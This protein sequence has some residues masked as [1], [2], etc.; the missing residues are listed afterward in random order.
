MTTPTDESRKARQT[1]KS[2]A[3]EP[4]CE[5]GCIDDAWEAGAA[6]AFEQASKDAANWHGTPWG[7]SEKLAARGKEQGK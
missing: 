5:H 7:L 1:W 6:W 3:K 2:T 4:M